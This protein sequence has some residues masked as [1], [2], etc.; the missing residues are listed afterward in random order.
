MNVAERV[1]AKDV[2]TPLRNIAKCPFCKAERL[3]KADEERVEE[4][5]KRVEANDACAIHVLGNHYDQ[6]GGGWFEQ[7][8]WNN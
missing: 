4:L 7:R 1:F 6:G 8:Q 2:S 3:G 5:M